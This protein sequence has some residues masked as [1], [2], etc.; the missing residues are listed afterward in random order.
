MSAL[1]APQ[2]FDAEAIPLGG[3]V[4]I[5]A[6]AGTGKTFALSSLY[7]RLLVEHDLRPAEILVV[8]F[9]QAA[10]AELRDRIRSRIREALAEAPEASERAT[11]LRRAL[12]EF[13]E[14]AISTIHGFCQRALQEHAFESGLAFSSE[15][16]EKPDAIQ[17]ALVHDLAAALLA[18]E[19]EA[20]RAWLVAG[21][22]KK[23]WAFDPASLLTLAKDL[24]GPDESMPILPGPEIVREADGIDAG[25]L[26]AGADAAWRA[27]AESFRARWEA[28]EKRLCDRETPLNRAR[29]KPDSIETAWRTTLE[30]ACRQA[31]E[32]T[33]AAERVGIA[34]PECLGKYLT[35]EQIEKG[36][37]GKNVPP[38]DPLFDAAS[39][40]VRALAALDRGFD[41]KAI[42]LRRR[43]VERVRAAGIARRREQH[44]LF[45][46][47]LLAELRAALEAP[48][49]EMLVAAL[50]RRHRVALIDEFQDTDAVQYAIFRRVWHVAGQADAG[51]GLFLI[52]DPKQAIYAFRGADLRTYL[53]ARGDAAGAVRT[54]GA[55]HRAEP[56]LVEAVNALFAASARPF[57][58]PEI[59][60]QA[61]TA[62]VRADRPAYHAP[63]RFAP[64]LRV[65]FLEQK[66]VE[67]V[68]GN[69]DSRS[70]IPLR[71]G[72]TRWMQSLARDVAELLESGTTIGGRPIAPSDVAILARRKSELDAARRALEAI[73][74]PCVSRGEGNVF[75]SREAWEL[76][77]LLAAW[78]HPGDSRRL[79]AALSTGAHGFDAPALLDLVDDSVALVTV[80]ERFAEYGRVWSQQGFGR[81]FATWRAREGV[82][83]RLLGHADG[84][85]RLTN[86]LHLAELLARVE[87]ERGA[88]RSGLA[89]WLDRAIADE[90]TR[91]TL[92]S[93]AS[94]LRLER[95]DEAVQLVTLHASKGLEYEVVYLPCLWE[96]F[97]SRPRD[98][99]QHPPIR[100]HDP[101]AGRTLDL[102]AEASA[103]AAHRAAAEAEATAE[104]LRL[105]Y[106]GLTRAKRHC[107]VFWGRVGDAW[108]KSPLTRLVLGAAAER[109]AEPPVDLAAFAKEGGDDLWRDAWT[110]LARATTPGAIR[111]EPSRLDPP[112]RWRGA[113]RDAIPLA[114]EP[115]RPLDLRPL[116]TTS[117][118]ALVRGGP[119]ASVPMAGP[120]ATGR[121]L[122]AEVESE[123]A[124]TP[125]EALPDLAGEMHRFPR[126]AE[127]GTLL[128]EV[129]ERVDFSR[130]DDE[131][132]RVLARSALARSP[133]G[134]EWVD[135]IV[136]VARSVARTPL[137]PEPSLRLGDLPPDR[138]LPELEFTLAAPGGGAGPGFSPDALARVLGDAPPESPARR[139]AERA[140]TLAWP[141]L[142]GFLRGFIDA[143][144]FDGTRWFVVDYKSN[145]LGMR[146][147]DYHPER[148]LAPMIEHDYVL[149]YLLYV[150]AVDRHLASRLDDYDY[151]RDFG[152]AYYL[153]LRGLA[154]THAPGCGVFFD[155]PDG[156]TIRRVS[157]LLGTGERLGGSDGAKAGARA[158]AEAKGKAR[159]EGAGPR[160][161]A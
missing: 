23:R 39:V 159:G 38:R 122:D 48:D 151:E 134:A 142:S 130:D 153:F 145:H 51:G 138:I 127:A 2:A 76:A 90:A 71:F 16:V 30:D 129:L 103:Y 9:T 99:G 62:A 147:R 52:G 91:D 105:L 19:D 96:S 12:R 57:D 67:A 56:A 81:A 10:T 44:V 34:P 141:A 107:V 75:E 15:L 124:V 106:V 108:P 133:L 140:R 146:Q 102:G 82:T 115:P 43:F 40:L 66:A 123:P 26:A 8:T 132:T 117:F 25:A 158:K 47:D 11:R 46:D 36:T 101:A 131:A 113:L 59:A 55:N 77:S 68:G 61:V 85:R 50:R 139:Y 114:F 33:S 149:Q 72:R 28:V 156:A 116:A 136:H 24:L 60:F 88:S 37:N 1:P 97:A 154:E 17:R 27:F 6:S 125:D 118:S 78:L 35:A 89:G 18:E 160:R 120:L 128:H 155:R 7:L 79:R 14:A 73:G 20:F 143:V 54:L 157:A 87:S 29:Y 135:P 4:F 144:F 111:L 64:G 3:T 32:A 49:G 74:I 95:D 45:F 80:A 104:H 109:M 150:V 58:L 94:L 93:D 126:G 70:P 161:G 83:E 22:G 112:A 86:W 42:A 69:E 21:A 63:E 84:D 31:E 110:S 152:G 13:D 92:G 100:F 148:L 119:R 121:D 65:S 41:T 98:G 53:A 5:E 137:R